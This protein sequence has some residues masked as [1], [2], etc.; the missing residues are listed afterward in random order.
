MSKGDGHLI[1]VRN[2]EIM[3]DVIWRAGLGKPYAQEKAGIKVINPLSILD[4]TL[5][6]IK[7]KNLV[8][9]YTKINVPRHFLVN[10]KSEIKSKVNKFSNGFVL[11]PRKGQRSKGVFVCKDY[12]GVPKGIRFNNYL[13]E[14][15]IQP[16]DMLKESFL[17]LGVWL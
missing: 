16:V 4:L 10:N 8:K 1:D 15:L 11:K 6:K 14:E 3:P 13:M 7:T 2:K 17:K 9:K 5:D 12:G